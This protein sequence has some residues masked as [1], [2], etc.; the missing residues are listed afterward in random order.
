MSDPV[1]NKLT[2]RDILKAT[3]AAGFAFGIPGI[4]PSTVFGK[5]APSNRINIGMIG[6]GRQAIHV[7][8]LPFL[9]SKDCRVVAVCDVDKWRLGKARAKVDKFYKNADCKAYTDWRQVVGRDDID[10]IMN[11]TS[12]QWHVPISLAAVRKGKHVSCEKPLTLSIAEGRILADAAKKH[13]VVFRT[14]SECRSNTYM[15][16]T[17]EL[18]INGY[19]GNIKRIEV[20]VP[21][22]DKA[23]GNAKPMEIPEELDYNMWVGPAPMKPY[24][25]DRVHP[26][27]GYGRP[28]WMRCRDTCE[29]MIT[30]WG[31]HL[32]DVAQSLNGTER[33]GPISVEGTGKYPKPGSGLWD[34]LTEFRAQ[35]KYANGVV[36]DYLIKV[37]YLRVEGDEGWIQAHWHSKG[38]L[39]AHDRS[40]FQTKFRKSDIRLPQRSDKGDFIYAIKNNCNTM[41]DAEVGHRTCSMGQLAHIAIQRGKKL[42]WNPK[43]ERFT[44][45]DKANKMLHRSYR[46]PWG[47]QV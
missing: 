30:N 31:T 39:Q 37:P 41:A 2:R 11:S 27:H 47:L 29:G 19:L 32:I 36:L 24:T 33:T 46:K 17:S 8:T 12:D 10:A 45:D 23:G 6:M 1:R 15:H 34:V 20:G 3:G 42:N 14:D 7:N 22:G 13:G 21:A 16:L 26:R 5:E 40:I 25:V 35:Y 9:H 44:D 4:V 43:T 38:G 28:G 18:A